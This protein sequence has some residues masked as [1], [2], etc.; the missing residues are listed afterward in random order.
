MAEMRQGRRRCSGCSQ[1]AFSPLTSRGPGGTRRSARLPEL[2]EVFS[3]LLPGSGPVVLDAV[4]QFDHVA[5]E[6]K[7]VFLQPRDVELFTR[8]AALEL[9]VDVLVVVSDNSERKLA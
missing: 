3:K 5:L 4:A 8:S 7:L 6:F 9:A 1:L 2:A